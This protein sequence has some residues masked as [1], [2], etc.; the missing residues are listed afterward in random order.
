M[1]QVY[2]A[3]WDGAHYLVVR[4]RVLNSWWGSNSVV[5]LSA[6]A[7]AA[8]LAIRNA[9]GGGT[10]QDW[11]LVKKLLSGAWR[12]AGSVAYRGERTLP[13]TMDA[14]DRALESAERT[15]PQTDDIAMET[16]AALQSLFREDARTPPPFSAARATLRELSIALPPPTRGAPNWA[17]ALILAQRLVAEVGAWS[18]GLPPAL[19][20]QAGQWA[21]PGGGRLNNERKERAARREFEE[22]LGIWLGQGR[23]ACDLRARLFPDGGGSFSLVRFRTTAE[24]LLR[25]AQEAENNVQA[26]ASSPARPQSCLVTDWEVASIGRVPVANLRNVLGARV[27]VP[28]EGTLEVDEA[29]ASARPGS[30]EI[31]WY[32]EIAA[33]LSPA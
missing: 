18:D 22:E 10:E 12:A 8:V 23:A 15:H 26:S 21:L 13:R 24:E 1:N 30:Q 28:G 14:L 27:E 7:M 9:S 3:V 33:L 19:V 2:V 17:A 11:D 6:E 32:R 4:K 29:L 31:G 25:M 16:L 20:N 5:V